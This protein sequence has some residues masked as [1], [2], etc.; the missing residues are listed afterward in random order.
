MIYTG[1][2]GTLA[3]LVFIS[4]AGPAFA[5]P[6]LESAVPAAGASV[7]SSPKEIRLNFSEGIVVKFSGLELKDEGGHPIKTGDPVP[8]SKDPKQLVVPLSATLS[9]G[10]YTVSWHAVSEDTHRVNGEYAF[11]VIGENAPPQVKS[12]GVSGDDPAAVAASKDRDDVKCRCGDRER[13]DRIREPSRDGERE[14]DRR[15]RYHDRRY[16]SRPPECVVD[17]EGYKYCRVR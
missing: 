3:L 2:I 10:S 16:N 14:S 9:S 5:H 7:S 17:D 6:K 1:P 8:D 13:N 4:L 15:E 12:E 11:R